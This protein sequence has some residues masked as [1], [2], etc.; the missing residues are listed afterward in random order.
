MQYAIR[1]YTADPHFFRW[2]GKP[3]I[4][5]WHPIGNGRTL[6][7]W[8]ALRRQVDPGH[9]LIWSAEG[10]DVSLLTVFDGLHLFSAA[11]W[12]LLDGTI[13]GVDRGFRSRI[14]A[15]NAAHGTHRIWTAGV[16]PGADDTRIPGR[17]NPHRVPRDNGATYRASWL[18]AMH[19]A[20]DWITI[21]SFNEWF[22]GTMIEPSLTYGNLYLSLT[23]QLSR[24]WRRGR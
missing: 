7:T 5:I 19:S 23:R 12:A 1:H 4:F 3:V 18:G 8:A 21:T 10:T 17:A 16:Q 24:Q 15:Y 14:D 13:S 2:H 22:E 9:H 6:S 20:P 11:Y